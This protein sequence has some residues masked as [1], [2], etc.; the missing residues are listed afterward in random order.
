MGAAKKEKRVGSSR[1]GLH[2]R[3]RTGNRLN[4]EEAHRQAL[5]KAFESKD[6]SFDGQV[7]VGVS[8]TGI[9]CRPV[10]PYMPKLDNCTFYETAAEAE[11]AG[12][13]PCL[14]C[15]PEIAPG[16]SPVDAYANL[17]QRAASLLKES[18]TSG[19]SLERLAGRLGYTDRH[20][21][22]AFQR[23]FDVTPLEYLQTCRL[24]LAKSL[25]ADTELPVAQVAMAAGF[26]SV[27]RF[28]DVFKRRYRLTPS[29]L[30][31]RGRREASPEGTVTLRIG[32]RPPYRFEALLGFFRARML[33]GV[34][35]V[36]NDFYAR[37][38]RIPLDSGGEATG[39]VR[40]SND[41][42]R[43]ALSVLMSESLLPA[44]S[45]VMARLRRQF[46]TDCNPHAVYEGIASLNETVSGA[47][48][49][50]T[51]L[52]GCFDG[53][54]TAVRAVLG[55][56]VSVAAANKL[57]ARIV[58]T[59]G[60]PIDTGIEGLE[61][62]FPTP[63]DI[64]ALRPIEEAL[65]ELGVIKARARTIAEVAR[66]LACSELDFNVGAVVSE[67]TERLLAVKGIG[68]WTANYLAMRVLGSPDAFLE[69]DAGI[70]HALPGLSPS[71]RLRLAE[72]WRPWRSYATIA[73]WNSLST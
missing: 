25:L 44:T 58:A 16:N 66:L 3:C 48:V 10:C 29:D 34:E 37:T 54:E 63:D 27:R 55:Q 53:F 40:V 1:S 64:L 35:V 73:L 15:R 11:K 23:K 2:E 31:K 69:T 14:V 70:K 39:W 4:R 33:Q 45:Q 61:R 42:E 68:P 60:I 30:R 71:E 18:C 7:F 20:L 32:Y 22:R 38:V 47:A 21:R 56:Q 19:D 28:N 13:R 46:D 36:G 62:V 50:G 49:V 24:Q 6:A 51:R 43:N 9:Y 57:A 8:S 52:P 5:Y 26:G 72:Q 59:C 41:A 65:G 17:A 12:Y 67:Q